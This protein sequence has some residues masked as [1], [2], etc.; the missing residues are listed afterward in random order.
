MD[1]WCVVWCGMWV[2]RC[3]EGPS[4]RGMEWRR[5]GKA[6]NSAKWTPG[7]ASQG[8]GQHTWS[9][10]LSGC[11]AAHGGS[12]RERGEGTPRTGRLAKQAGCG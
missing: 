11:G 12:A 10:C 9:V 2:S 6:L 8:D 3:S 1:V 5:V 4:A 7:G